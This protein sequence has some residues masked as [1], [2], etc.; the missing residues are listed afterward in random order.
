MVSEKWQRSVRAAPYLLTAGLAVLAGVAPAA[1]E[2]PAVP[3]A[4]APGSRAAS[5]VVAPADAPEAVRAGADI[6][7]DGRH[8]EQTL[9]RS[10]LA[11]PRHRV[12][13]DASPA[14]S[15]EVEA[16]G[17]H[18]VVW[19]P[20]TYR[21]DAP[22][23]VPDGADLV[24][25]SE[26]AVFDYTPQSGD[27]VTVTGAY[28]SRYR[29][30]TIRSASDGAALRI[31]PGE[32][33]PTLM[34]EITFTGLVGTGVTDG[35]PRGTGLL[36]DPAQQ[37]VATNR[38]AGTDVGG[39]ETCVAVRPPAAADEAR[40]GFGKMDTNHI[41]LSYVR[42]CRTGI[43][44]D[45][46]RGVDSNMW[47]VNVDASLPDS[48]AIRTSGVYDRWRVIMGTWGK[49]GTAL[50]LDPG[51]R[52]NVIDM[53]PPLEGFAFR[54]DSG[55]GTNV[56][57]GARAF[58]ALPRPAATTAP[59]SSIS[60]VEQGIGPDGSYNLLRIDGRFVGVRQDLGPISFALE[61][62]G[63]RD[64]P[65][66]L[67]RAAD[68]AEA[69]RRV[70]ADGGSETDYRVEPFRGGVVALHRRLGNVAIGSELI[71]TRTLS[72]QILTGPT[73]EAV[74]AALVAALR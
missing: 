3:R 69:L 67:Y 20:G 34:S 8:D 11:A 64:L 68:R 71:G 38:I 44:V 60:L 14:D 56:F 27:A 37:N 31:A 48:V 55:N 43:L 33:M 35:A 41:W 51:A 42:R 30:G 47:D 73:P 53:T 59:P 29:F 5:V 13:V 74:R 4:A 26:G 32:R 16:L 6:V 28:R 23:I 58:A 18:S 10:L 49:G 50:V 46:R 2:A 39:F 1:A 15:E 9:L 63:E 22:L 54:D 24:I 21:L 52:Y 70:V 25:Q 7:A 72:P 65:P 17:R 57:I 19:L 66:N 45:G 61:V 62:L 36:I 40:P 12:A